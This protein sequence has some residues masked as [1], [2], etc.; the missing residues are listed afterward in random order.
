MNY[1]SVCSGIEAASVAWKPLGWNPIA[2]SE[3]DKF[4]SSVLAHH[5]PEVPNLGDMKNYEK[6]IS[7]EPELIIGGTPCQSYSTC[8]LRQ[9]L[10]DPRGN[11]TLV[12]LAMVKKFNPDWVV[13]E[14][15]PG[16]LSDQTNAF[17]QF[18]NGLEECGYNCAWRVLDSQYF[19][20]P[21]R[22]RR[23][24]VVASIREKPHPANVLFEAQSFAKLER[25]SNG[26]QSS[27]QGKGIIEKRSYFNHR[28]TIKSK[29]IVTNHGGKNWTNFDD[30]VFPT[31]TTGG[32]KTLICDSNKIRKITPIECERLQGFPE[33]YTKI[34]FKGKLSEKS[35][36]NKRYKAC[37]NSM[38][39]PV[40]QWIGKRIKKINESRIY[41]VA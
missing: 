32:R 31:L 18:I 15:V 6:W 22:R 3:I 14:N 7:I 9:G 12:F 33:N 27:K 2:F 39:V 8:G 17:G 29:I 5:W 37:G 30:V 1:L 38:T 19:G 35:S 23:V 28:K 34:P 20:V 26:R 4:A 41:E 21:Q 40:V 11:L 25:N 16:I 13:W 24:Y 36:R 10:R